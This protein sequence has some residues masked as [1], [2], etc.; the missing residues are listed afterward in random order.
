M[1]EESLQRNANIFL[2]ITIAL[3]AFGLLMIFSSSGIVTH[4]L[5]KKGMYYSLV[6]QLAWVSIGFLSIFIIIILKKDLEW[7]NKYSFLLLFLLL[8]LLASTLL[9]HT[10][11]TARRW[12][13][14][15]QPSELVKVFFIL[16][17]SSFF[18]KKEDSNESFIKGLVP[19]CLILG[20]IL[21]ILAVQPHYGM[22]VFFC[23]LTLSVFFIAGIKIRHLLLLLLIFSIIMAPIIGSKEYARNRIRAF[24]SKCPIACNVKWVLKGFVENTSDKE[25]D[26]WQVEQSIIALGSG[27]LFGVGLGKSKQKLS[28]VPLPYTDFIFSIIGEELGFILGSLIVFVLFGLFAYFGFSIACQ[29]QS[30]SGFFLAFSLTFSIILQAIVNIAIVSDTIP[31]TG[32]PLPFI[33][34]GG[35]SLLSN[36]ISVGLIINVARSSQHNV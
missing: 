20:V 25:A 12:I 30:Q 9:F 32:L 31:T 33:S 6:K 10:D 7:W 4:T 27:G 8:L 3:V 34:Y 24:L 29:A 19:P 5:S 35:S 18:S 28:W 1:E 13:M 2:V 15:G 16:Y 14:G 36:L 23:L 21:S 22:A 26:R 17:L 11:K